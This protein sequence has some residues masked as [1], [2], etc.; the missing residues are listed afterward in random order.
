MVQNNLQSL[1]FRNILKIRVV[2]DKQFLTV[3]NLMRSL[4]FFEFCLLLSIS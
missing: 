4:G 1:I 3:F 2:P